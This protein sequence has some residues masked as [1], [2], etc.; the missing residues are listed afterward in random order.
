MI[1][2]NCNANKGSNM[3]FYE[4]DWVIPKGTKDILIVEAVEEYDNIIIHYTSNRKAYPTGQLQS[5]T[6]VYLKEKLK[7]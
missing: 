1:A 6:D 5:L 7:N 2:L 3:K 4:G